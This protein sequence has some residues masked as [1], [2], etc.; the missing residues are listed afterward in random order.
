M[1][2]S[3]DRSNQTGEYVV[4]ARRYRPQ[5]FEDLVGQGTVSQALCNAITTD[6]VG[7][8]Y[9]FTGARG[10]GKTSTARILSKAL[11]CQTGPTPTPCGRCD[12]CL[13]VA[14]GDDVDVLEIDGASN[15]GIDEIRQLRSNVGIRPSRARF[16]VYI[17]DEV[18]MLTKEAFNA[19]LKTLEEPPE[20]VKF[21]FC[22]TEPGKI[23]ITVLSRC[24]RFD[25]SPVSA[26][27]IVQRLQQ[28][29]EQEGAQ[30]EPAALQ[31]LARR[32]AG[33]MRDSQSLLEQLLSFV[34]DQI[35]VDDVHTML[36]T[37]RD[38]RLRE[39]VQPLAD[40]DAAGA[41]NG[42]GRAMAEGVDPGQ[43][44]EQIV[45]C[46]RDMMAAH[47]GCSPDLLL[48]HA[49]SEFDSLRERAESWGMQ[50]LLAAV[51]VVDQTISRM[52]QSV[53]SRILL[54]LALV[55]IAQLE[56]LDDLSDL[57]QRLDRG[58]AGPAKTA[59]P[60]SKK[61][62]AL[63]KTNADARGDRSSGASAPN[64]PTD[65][66]V[67][68]PP[69]SADVQAASTPPAEA[70]L[71]DSEPVDTGS[72]PPL[73]EHQAQQAWRAALGS[74]NDM[75]A[76]CASHADSVAISGPNRLVVRF[77]GMY[78]SSKSFC[79]RPARKETLE[80]ALSVA[81]GRPLRLDFHVLKEDR[82]HP[83]PPKPVV[84][85]QQLKQQAASH[86]LVALA[87]ELFDAE[88]ISVELRQDVK[89]SS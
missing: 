1:S 47:V 88:V 61:K 82:A 72:H 3:E 86:P 70:K 89:K 79:E 34:G 42:L 5:S 43:L 35:S 8:A 36:G 22:T 7:H 52:R 26:E 73:T 31:L 9:L 41:L 62:T 51:Q 32:A 12:I 11:N 29:V 74:L 63:T 48:Y 37:A 77:R 27:E 21:I 44:A 60:N 14:N 20:H 54:E 33:S 71:A 49:P 76:D 2:G 23:P 28:I 64:P 30:A 25:F 17:I 75:T 55:R 85:R 16:K 80:K 10:V 15:R 6:R 58:D 87:V 59:V 38:E 57:I 50:S 84:S 83:T 18:H 56:Q 78:N 81:A 40:R 67:N 39:L 66:A 13:Q 46:L 19:L 45:G 53:H 65:P 24:Q 68:A 69:D 4:V